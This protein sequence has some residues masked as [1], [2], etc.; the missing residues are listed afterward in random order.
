MCTDEVKSYECIALHSLKTFPGTKG[1]PV[2]SCKSLEAV[3][4]FDWW[5]GESYI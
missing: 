4:C 5:A 1:D 2:V 3:M